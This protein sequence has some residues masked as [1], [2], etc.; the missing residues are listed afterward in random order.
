MRREVLD[1]TIRVAIEEQA[2]RFG[3]SFYELPAN[4]QSWLRALMTEQLYQRDAPP[5]VSPEVPDE[6]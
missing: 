3:V 4:V 5:L 1:E 2:E 6:E